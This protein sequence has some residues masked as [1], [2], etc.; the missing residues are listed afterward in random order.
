M[1]RY[2]LLLLFAHLCGLAMPASSEAQ[3][4]P[5]DKLK[6]RGQQIANKLPKKLD[7]SKV[8]KHVKLEVPTQLAIPSLPQGKQTVRLHPSSLTT[9]AD[10]RATYAKLESS[11]TPAMKQQ[12]SRVRDYVKKNG[13]SFEVGITSVSGK[14]LR[15][16]T[17]ARLPSADEWK[18]LSEGAQLGTAAAEQQEDPSKQQPRAPMGPV[19]R[20]AGAPPAGAS[21]YS[22]PPG[23]PAAMWMDAT[24]F[25]LPDSCD[26]AGVR[27]VSRDALPPVRDQQA[28]GSCWAFA[29]TA[30]LEISQA[31]LNGAFY[32]FSEQSVLDCATGSLNGDAG[33]CDG[34]YTWDV[35]EFAGRYGPAQEASVPYVAKA[36]TCAPS[37][38][39]PY[40][41]TSYGPTGLS[42]K[43]DIAEIKK[44]I[45][46]YGSVVA[47]LNAT[48]AFLSYRSGVF[49]EP[50]PTAGGPHAIG[51]VGWDDSK[52]A[53]IL[54]NSW[55]TG[56]GEAGYAWIS[57]GSNDVGDYAYWVK[58]ASGDGGSMGEGS[59]FGAFYTRIPVIENGMNEE[60]T[61]YVQYA[62]W[63]GKDGLR[64]LPQQG[65]WYSYRIPVGY[66]GQLGSPFL[67]ALRASRLLV[68]AENGSKSKVW[69]PYKDS[70]L[71]IVPE[72][73][74][75]ATTP[76]PY[77]IKLEPSAQPAPPVV[78]PPAP[79]PPVKGACQEWSVSRILF[80]AS[81]LYEWD[82]G[83]APDIFM[84]MV[85]GRK[86]VRSTFTQDNFVKAW[87][88]P[89]STPLLLKVGEAVTLTGF[90]KD[91]V[92]EDTIETIKVVIPAKFP[93]G[94]WTKTGRYSAVEFTGSCSRAK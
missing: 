76:E 71:D 82:V 56:W 75:W 44:A 83:T 2:L 38:L 40:M 88:F 66:K 13:L 87:D 9:A 12:L 89:T 41:R 28:C 36:S 11:A 55:G 21:Y 18:N 22:A 4:L 65:S 52:K 29:A 94:R 81:N 33:T 20:G 64:W 53:W 68:Y 25:T 85:R 46:K 37:S 67:G 48:D 59:D 58:A 73:G 61:L 10:L 63:T 8:P 35:F 15:E 49:K 51:L 32:D 62:G 77:V 74:Y 34:G 1:R 92:L 5:L 3:A 70:P 69:A 45:C 79:P 17:G 80:T 90:D 60:V 7:P 26:P 91:I 14:P 31:Y 24:A 93:S 47:H 43:A 86:T 39:T 50:N 6:K 54:R 57:F 30:A 42:M 19:A 23:T 78:V 84:S 16:I 27:W 72:G